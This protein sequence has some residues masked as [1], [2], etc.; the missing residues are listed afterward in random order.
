MVAEKFLTLPDRMVRAA[1][2]LANTSD[3]G[4]TLDSAVHLA[5][6]NVTGCDSAAITLIK[7]KAGEFTSPAHTDDLALAADQLQYT[8]GEGP[9]LQ[10][11]WEERVVHSPDLEQEDRWP[12]WAPQVVREHGA[13]SVLCFQL[14][15]DA[16]TLGA[17]NLYSRTKAGFDATDRD[18]GF[19][20]AAQIAVAVAKAEQIGQLAEALQ[21]RTV[22]GQACGILMERFG[23]DG[24]TAF[25][26]LARISSE[27][28]TK[29][30]D[31][32]HEV[33]ETRTFPP[34]I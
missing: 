32:A 25:G 1:R 19:A 18:V 29:V 8:L 17:L 11:A 28:N 33:V 14:F 10:A 31:L 16:D 24:G 23:L 6:A 30:R 22:I 21:S 26:V 13:L 9:C 3:A 12:V 7:K 27:T 20:L 5:A 34:R 15:T 4:T 2:E